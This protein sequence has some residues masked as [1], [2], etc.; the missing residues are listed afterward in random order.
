LKKDIKLSYFEFFLITTGIW[1]EKKGY[2]RLWLHKSLDI[3]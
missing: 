3:S 1:F 2:K